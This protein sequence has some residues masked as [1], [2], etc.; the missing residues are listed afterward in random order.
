MQKLFKLFK[1]FKTYKKNSNNLLAIEMER[2]RI[3]INEAVYLGL[4]VLGTSNLAMYEFWYDYVR[5]K[6]GEKAKL[7]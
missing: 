4:S 7:S 3:L 1:L 6:Y 2:T 5:P